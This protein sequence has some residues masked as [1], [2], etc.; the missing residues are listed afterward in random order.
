M[1][2]EL[3]SVLGRDLARGM[4]DLVFRS[5]VLDRQLASVPSI[6]TC[7]S[8]ASLSDKGV[9]NLDLSIL[10]PFALLIS[11]FLLAGPRFVK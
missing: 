5:L 1:Q 8:L 7:R 4:G 2:L 6:S 10:F 9:T 3:N 11:F